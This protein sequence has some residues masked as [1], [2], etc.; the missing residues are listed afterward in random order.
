MRPLGLL[1]VAALTLSGC[2]SQE[3]TQGETSKAGQDAYGDW[4]EQMR[5]TPLKSEVAIND[6][7]AISAVFP[8]DSSVCT[9]DSGGHVHGF[10]QW[11]ESDCTAEAPGVLRP[12]RYLSVWADYNAAE[13]S[14]DDAV[15]LAC[16][17]GTSRGPLDATVPAEIGWAASCR[18]EES[19]AKE[20]LI[21]IFLS[22]ATEARAGFGPDNID[23]MYTM[24]LHTD[25]THRDADLR[26]FETFLRRL[27]LAGSSLTLAP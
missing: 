27:K 14:R 13:Y 19:D 3:P 25:V 6:E 5:H 16:S 21:V 10:Y 7:Y 23:V 12:D 11:L 8:K 2:Q 17:H 22:K 1:S 18:E 9:A 24:T 20:Q 15:E 4:L 26:T